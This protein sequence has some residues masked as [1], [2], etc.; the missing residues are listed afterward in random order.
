MRTRRQD[1]APRPAPKPRRA[2]KRD[3]ASKDGARRLSRER[4]VAVALALV[5]RDGLAA[6]LLPTR[7]GLRPNA[8]RW[9][10]TTISRGRPHPVDA[11]VDMRSRMSA[12]PRP[13]ATRSSA[14]ARWPSS[15]R[16]GPPLRPRLFP[17]VAVHGS[18]PPRAS[19]CS[20]R[21]VAAVRVAVPDPLR[22]ARSSGR[23]A[24]TLSALSSTKPPATRRARPRRSPSA[25][26]PSARS[27]RISLPPRPIQGPSTGKA[28]SRGDSTR[29]WRRSRRV[30][31]G[32]RRARAAGEVTLP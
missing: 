17:L 10:S 5:E 7:S 30:P 15:T 2:A 8:R 21:C 20:S 26:K 12:C 1:H 13:A 18:N 32:S 14:C 28:R 22:D 6:R 29:C 27:H 11:L 16:D 19:R 24:I 9:P 25:T 23:S 31:G 3:V 4:I